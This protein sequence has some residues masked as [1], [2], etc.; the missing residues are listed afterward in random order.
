[1]VILSTLITLLIVFALFSVIPLIVWFIYKRL[2]DRHA[3]TMLSGEKKGKNW[4]PPFVVVLIAFAA[5]VIILLGCIAILRT[6]FASKTEVSG[7]DVVELETV[8]EGERIIRLVFPGY[9]ESYCLGGTWGVL[10]APEEEIV[11]EYTDEDGK[12]SELTYRIPLEDEGAFYMESDRIGIITVE[13]EEIDPQD[14]TSVHLRGVDANGEYID[15]AM[16]IEF[17]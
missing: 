17:D 12:L 15:N 13:I 8:E 6:D 11:L 4:L 3:N 1:M 16:D 10:Y 2:F 5:E 7:P 9:N 14:V